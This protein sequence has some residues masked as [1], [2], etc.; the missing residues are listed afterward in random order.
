MLR[1][2]V[3]DEQGVALVLA[4][5]TMLV[6]SGLTSAVL[7][8]TALNHRNAGN[9]AAL[10]KAFL[11][12]EHGLALSE[13]LLYTAPTSSA[14]ALA[15]GQSAS[16]DGGTIHYGGT[17]CDSTTTP[18]C[19]S[20]QWTLTGTGTFDGLSR[21]VSTIVTVP[22]PTTVTT[23]TND[24]SVWSYIYVANPQHSATCTSVSNG[25]SISVPMY[26]NG[27]LCLTGGSHYYGSDLEVNG[28]L[29][30]DQGATVGKSNQPVAKMNAVQCTQQ[31]GAA[32]DGSHGNIWVAAPGVGSNVPPESMPSVNFTSEYASDVHSCGAGSTG[33]PANFFDN[34]T[35][36]NN[37]NGTINLFPSGHA[38][39]CKSGTSELKWDGSSSLLI[40]GV[41]FF[42][43]S[44][45][46]NAGGLHVVY[47][48][49][50]GGLVL[51]GTFSI[52][53][54]VTLCGQQ[55][56]KDTWDPSSNVLT[57]EVGC[58]N[59]NSQTVMSSATNCV[60]IAGGANVQAPV[61]DQGMFYVDNGS[62]DMA[63]ILTNYFTT[64]GGFKEMLPLHTVPPWLP[65]N[66]TQTTTTVTHPPNPPSGWNG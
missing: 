13:G 40:K 27:P 34:D 47:A 49:S 4:L 18:A 5:T 45:N 43:G 1:R 46:M 20:P 54:G 8:A 3:H 11:L 58:W 37:S 60:Y 21:T 64:A 26:V 48:N 19:A 53:N 28:L 56:C 23:N 65:A 22:P 10:E 39:D 7:A 29:T 12:A 55:A 31:G 63:P 42:D 25:V 57:L 6:L 33:V 32:C 9:S 62:S 59:P 50:S 52:S 36:P 16:Q 61:W 2:L 30:V 15:A 14:N 24:W 66:Q 44:I 17:Y 41:F 51:T 38:Y 35:T